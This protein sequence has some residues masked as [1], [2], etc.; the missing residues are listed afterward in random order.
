MGL[1]KNGTK[2]PP[3]LAKRNQ[4]MGKKVLSSDSSSSGP[5]ALVLILNVFTGNEYLKG[6]VS[7]VAGDTTLMGEEEIN[8]DK[9][10]RNLY[11]VRRRE[12][13]HL[14]AAN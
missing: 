14:L 9:D 8:C 13:E 11:S 1:A 2:F 7:N 5:L 10:L 4:R 3:T 12:L 6:M